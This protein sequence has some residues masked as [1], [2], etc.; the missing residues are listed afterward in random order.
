MASS[1]HYAWTTW[2]KKAKETPMPKRACYRCNTFFDVTDAS[3]KFCDYCSEYMM[4]IDFAPVEHPKQK[5]AFSHW[6]GVPFTAFSH[7]PGHKQLM[8]KG[9]FWNEATR[10]QDKATDCMNRFS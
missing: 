4:K 3:K 5:E 6:S 1:N 10:H 2:A 9:L 8:E 7:L